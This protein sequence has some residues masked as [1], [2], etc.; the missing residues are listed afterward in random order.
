MLEVIQNTDNAIHVLKDKLDEFP[1][2]ITHDNTDY[3][4]GT[5]IGEED[6]SAVYF[7]STWLYN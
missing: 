6:K 4:Y 2:T 7:K 3:V 1:P 5:F